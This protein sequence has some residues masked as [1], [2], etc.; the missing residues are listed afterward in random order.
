MMSDSHLS[1]GK[2]IKE[3]FEALSFCLNERS[4]RIWAAIEA[5]SYGWGGITMVSQAVGIDSKTIR[6]GLSELEDPGRLAEHRVRKSGGGRK[7]LTDKYSN[8]V[9]D[10]DSL[11][12]PV[13]RGDPES[14]LRW[15]CKSTYKLAEELTRQDYPISQRTVWKLLFELGYRLP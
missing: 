11:V 9:R 12:D 1:A 13:T 14:P 2:E 4:R 5:R 15:T 10:L 8:L 3:K 7:K 6:K